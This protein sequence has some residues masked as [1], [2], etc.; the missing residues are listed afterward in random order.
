[1]LDITQ[2]QT[3]DTMILDLAGNVIMGGGSRRLGEEVRRLVEAGNSNVLLNFENV[4]Y[5]DSSGVGELFSLLETVNKA[6]G[7]L[8]LSNLQPKVEEVLTLSGVLPVFDIYDD[9]RAALAPENLD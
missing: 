3:N 9:E 7:K 5:L 6:D 4:K 1:M 8:K 2:R